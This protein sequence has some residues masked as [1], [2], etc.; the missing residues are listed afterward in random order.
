MTIVRGPCKGTKDEISL[1]GY[2]PRRGPHFGGA[3]VLD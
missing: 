1:G 2:T 3:V